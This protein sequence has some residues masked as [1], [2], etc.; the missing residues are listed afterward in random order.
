M[1]DETDDAGSGGA[2]EATAGTNDTDPPEG[3]RTGDLA[4]GIPLILG[5]IAWVADGILGVTELG[6]GGT[7][8]E[9]GS[10]A[11]GLVTAG[12]LAHAADRAL[13]GERT[14]AAVVA[15]FAVGLAAAFVGRGG[16]LQVAGTALML[17]GVA[18][19]AYLT[20]VADGTGGSA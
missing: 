19:Y 10:L 14:V 9:T 7:T 5:G 8:V 18:A 20:F 6:V 11:T 2:G 12:F 15:T 16:T 1:T 3:F 17:L 13:V 4:A